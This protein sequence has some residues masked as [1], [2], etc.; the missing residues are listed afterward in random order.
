MSHTTN[1]VFRL[2]WISVWLVIGGQ[3]ST[4][5]A[6][7]QRA[8][9]ANFLER[10]CI[11]CHDE[12]T[13]EGDLDLQSLALTLDDADRFHRW[14]RVFDR[15]HEGE[16]PPDETLNK[17]ESSPFLAS[18]RDILNEAD[19]ARISTYGRVPTRRLTRAQYERNVC[20]LLAIDIP[21]SEYLPAESLTNGFDTV[22][23]S[24][25]IS[26]H[27]MAA[28]L[29]AAD[30]ALDASFNRLLTNTQSAN[31]HLD[32]TQLRRNEKRT[33]REP[34][35]RPEHKD[36]V[37]WS[38]RKNFYGRMHATVVP[39][40][41]RYRIRLRAHAIHPPADGRV[42][43][44]VESGVCNA[45]ASTLYWIDSF[46][47]NGDVA[48]YQFEAWIQAGHR[49]RIVPNDRGLRQVPLRMVDETAGK[50]E[51]L[52]LPGV[53]IKWIEMQRIDANH[54]NVRQALIGDL[55]LRSIAPDATT[56]IASAQPRFEIASDHPEQDLRTLIQSFAERAFRRKVTLA[57]LSPYVDF[58]L[59]RLQAGGTMR[60]ALRAA[61]RTIL[62]S[63]RFLYF[64]ETTGP[65]DDH[66]LANR[67]SH[68]LWGLGP[69]DELR[70]L[71]AAGQLNDPPVLHQ[72]TERLLNDARSAT[73]I[74]EFADQ[75]LM[76]HELSSTTP[77]GDL[78]PEY[79][80]V[81]HHSLA[82]ET[83]AFVKEMLDH[84]L[85]ATNVVDSNFTFLNSRLARHYHVDWPGGIGLQRVQLD[86]AS[87]RGGI[88]TQASVL[89][90]TA[91][92]TTT[93]PIIRGVWMLE[94]IMGQHV[95]P[96]PANVPAVE[97]D[98]RGAKS[99]R[100]QLN[101]HKDLDSCAACHVKIDPPG[102]ALESYDV[103]GGWREHYRAVSSSKKTG[104]KWADGQPVDPSHELTT[105]HF[106]DGAAFANI[107]GLKK[108]LA[109]HP[110][111]L[112]KSLASHLVTYA[113][114]AAPT[115]ADRE[116]LDAV[117]AATE[118]TNYGVRS[119][120][121]EVV[122]SSLFKHK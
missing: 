104:K 78:Y 45:T 120:V 69:D 84:D 57:E 43:C 86:P 23:K 59:A 103:I 38:T 74:H 25:Q 46:E 54:A 72:Q 9:I 22:S 39:E 47:A 122:Q 42:W 11:G 50:I 106:S 7:D 87:R 111:Q 79:D 49:L 107:E 90:V 64:E 4:V 24:Q 114:G 31:V 48:E 121:H 109:K 102:F 53:A 40:T 116:T 70:T 65:L 18:L 88:I 110:Q 16:M 6:A 66:A 98:I 63:P 100:D 56:A 36:I 33:N 55:E 99:I 80:D 115:F 17:Q 85:P 118:P 2:C 12:S 5:R 52:G 51:P 62:C 20:E 97:P 112:A 3:V 32:W 77:D 14:Q 76:L 19:A 113:T 21:L 96:P 30:A 71:A 108:L 94:R 58:S 81:L 75:W 89:K 10:N 119:L 35:G 28:Y 105:G 15:V 92:G 13:Q 60:D 26:D 95:P 73:F 68:F 27:S 91:N 93:S 44:S 83:H 37:S 41:G 82:Q 8:S 101:K 29:Q 1:I 117:V 67:L 34:E 61:Y